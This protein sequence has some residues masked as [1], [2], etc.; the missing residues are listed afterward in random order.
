MFETE[1]TENNPQENAASD[2]VEYNSVSNNYYN[3]MPIEE[4]N[5]QELEEETNTGQETVGEETFSSEEESPIIENCK[6]EFPGGND[7]LY[8]F[9]M[10][11]MYYPP[12]IK[13]KGIHGTVY[14]HFTVLK[15]GKIVKAVVDKGVDPAL[16]A[17]AVRLM[18]S[19]PNWKPKIVNGEP[20]IT[21][22]NYS[23][24]FE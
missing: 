17:E 24:N 2:S 6:A 10:E 23:I 9:V 3:E 1:S 5:S 22:M 4:N 13:A 11:H 18:E 12:D 8:D 14:V 16:D 7:A 19:M 15:D 20:V 21:V